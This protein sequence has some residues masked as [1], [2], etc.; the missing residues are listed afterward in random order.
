MPKRHAAALDDQVAADQPVLGQ[1]LQAGQG[2]VGAGEV[3]V[4]GD[5]RRHAS[6]LR[7]GADGPRRAVRPEVEIMVAEGGGVAPDHRQHLQL[8]A[9]LARGA[10]EGSAHAVVAAIQHQNRAE[11]LAGRPA[12][13][14]QGRQP[15]E[16]AAGG[17]VVRGPRRVVGGGR[18]ADQVRVEVVGVQDG[19]YLNAAYRRS[20]RHGSEADRL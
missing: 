3:G 7:R 14:D 16:A 5:H 9:G 13:G 11:R 15:L 4:R 8:A 20:Q 18:H 10:R 12:L 6:R 17:V 1:R 19:G 2:R